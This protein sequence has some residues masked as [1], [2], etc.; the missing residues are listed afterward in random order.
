MAES[1]GTSPLPQA[2]TLE[3]SLSRSHETG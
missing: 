3:L 1:E 2:V